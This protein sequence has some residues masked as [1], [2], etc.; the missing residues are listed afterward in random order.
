[1]PRLPAKVTRQRAVTCCTDGNC[2]DCKE[3]ESRYRKELARRKKNRF[4]DPVR[5]RITE[6]KTEWM[7]QAECEGRDDLAWIGDWEPVSNKR[8]GKRLAEEFCSVCPVRLE[9]LKYGIATK[10]MGVWGGHYLSWEPRKKVTNLLAK[11]Q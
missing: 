6:Q 9:C 7:D 1:M 3:A 10:S 2:E 4:T 11:M 8:T 5:R